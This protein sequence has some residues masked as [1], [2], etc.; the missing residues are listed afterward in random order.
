[1][2]LVVTYQPMS[3]M[4]CK[5]STLNCGSAVALECTGVAVK[6]TFDL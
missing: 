3:F 5:C 2:N 4:S 1:M 6:H